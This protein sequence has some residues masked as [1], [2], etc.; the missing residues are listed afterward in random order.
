MCFSEFL[1]AV[2]LGLISIWQRGSFGGFTTSAASV[3][4]ESVCHIFQL[5]KCIQAKKDLHTTNHKD[6]CFVLQT[7]INLC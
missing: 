1:R 7:L 6:R 2:I 5:S 4:A 3:S